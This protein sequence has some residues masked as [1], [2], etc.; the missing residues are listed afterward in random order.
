MSTDLE[1]VLVVEK[2][3]DLEKVTNPANT[4]LVGPVFKT[5]NVF[6]AAAVSNNQIVFNNILAPSLTTVMKRT[7][8]VEMEVLVT[9]TTGGGGAQQGTDPQFNAVNAA[10][11]PVVFLNGGVANICLSAFPLSGVCSSVD[12]R[13]NGGSTN[14]A[15][16]S[17]SQI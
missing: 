15:L 7:L 4:V 17:Y 13:L 3:M 2:L 5:L 1:N 8:R 6:P 12:I 14:C 9:V 16:A 10:G 11:A